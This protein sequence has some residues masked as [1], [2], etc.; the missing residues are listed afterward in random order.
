LHQWL[1]SLESS[2]TQ[3]A[4]FDQIEDSSLSEPVE[5]EVQIERREF[6]NRMEL[7]CYLHDVLAPIAGQDVILDPGMWS[8]LAVFF[9]DQLCPRDRT[10]L[11]TPHERARW[12]PAMSDWKKYYRH[13]LSGP[14]SIYAAHRDD[15]QR[16]L[17]VLANPVDRPG[18]VYEQLASHQDLA[19]SAPVM[20][21]ATRLYVE[22]ETMRLKYGSSTKGP[23]APRRLVEVLLQFDL[24][25]DLR[26]I[27][28]DGLLSMLP[29][30]FDRFRSGG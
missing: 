12:V 7:A 30:E 26:S 18:E 8:W 25:W 10:G 13:L 23:G 14:Y 16:A 19:T 22:P 24:S 28:A 29:T 1:D 2:P 11:L 3:S 6:G 17:A 15:P 27:H 21:V 9:F 20:E 4:H 5:P